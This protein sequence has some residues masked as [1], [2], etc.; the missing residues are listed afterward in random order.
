[1]DAENLYREN[2]RRSLYMNVTNPIEQILEAIL[3]ETTAVWIITSY[4]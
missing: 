4:L 3:N 1:M 2:A